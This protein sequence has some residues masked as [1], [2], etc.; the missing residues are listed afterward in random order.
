M[1]APQGSPDMMKRWRMTQTAMIEPAAELHRVV[2]GGVFVGTREHDAFLE[3]FR[4]AQRHVVAKAA[5][6]P[7]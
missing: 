6:L 2:D 4:H 3:R 5:A 1:K 7:S